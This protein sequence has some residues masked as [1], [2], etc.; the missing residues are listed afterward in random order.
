MPE[1]PSPTNSST[2][3]VPHHIF[4]KNDS[5]QKNDP[6]TTHVLPCTVSSK[7]SIPHSLQEF[8]FWTFWMQKKKSESVETISKRT[9]PLYQNDSTPWERFCFMRRILL[10]GL[11][12]LR[13]TFL[14][15]MP[16]K[17]VYCSNSIIDGPEGNSGGIATTLRK[18]GK[19]STVRLDWGKFFYK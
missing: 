19:Q 17:P 9:I 4:Q 8:N 2:P 12:I 7:R 10:H 16:R 13:Q 11:R 3:H 14:I 15:L 5:Q 18:Q 1:S 6:V